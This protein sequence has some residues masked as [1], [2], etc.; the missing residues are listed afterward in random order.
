VAFA[1]AQADP[2]AR[3]KA[4]W[5]AGGALYVVW[6]AGT[7]IGAVAGSAMGDP[8]AYGIDA[9]F[10]AA[11]LALVLPSLKERPA[12]RTALAGATIALV[13]APFLPP[14]LPVLLALLGLVFA[15]PLPGARRPRELEESAREVRA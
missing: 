13:S 3:R 6:N 14:G 2:V 10:P 1:L 5:L 11:M 4:Y 15:L 8:D 12:L 9:A 7:V